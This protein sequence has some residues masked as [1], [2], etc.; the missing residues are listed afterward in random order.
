M[1]IE[2]LEIGSYVI[3]G[4]FLERGIVEIVNLSW[5]KMVTYLY[6]KGHKTQLSHIDELISV[7]ITPELLKEFGFKYE[8]T[9]WPIND[10]L[11]QISTYVLKSAAGYER[12]F[13]VRFFEDVQDKFLRIEY[14]I[15]RKY[16]RDLQ[17]IHEPKYLHNLQKSFLLATGK[18]LIK[19]LK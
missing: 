17:E 19:P 15:G 4:K 14:R 13:E 2:E 5:G 1:R 9:E 8:Y 10:D 18:P 16:D 11:D 3:D 7:E 12:D 6:E